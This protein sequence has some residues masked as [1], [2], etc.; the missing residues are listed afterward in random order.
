MSAITVI[1]QTFYAICRHWGG[2]NASFKTAGSI[3]SMSSGIDSA[4]LNMVWSEKPLEPADADALEQI[5]RDFQGRGLPFWFWVFPSAKT[6]TTIDALKTAGFTFVHDTPCML[7]D[8]QSLPEQDSD[9]SM[10]TLRRVE[11][12]NDLEL[13][14]DVSFSGFEFPAET[15]RQYEHFTKSFDLHPD[16][17][18]QLLLA[19][20]NDRPV[21]TSILFLT[22]KAAGIYFVTT[23]AEYRKKGIGLALTQATLQRAKE[24][25]VRHAT[26]QSSPDGL[27]VYE[28]AGFKEYCRAD[29]FS[30]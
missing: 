22:G 3:R 7:A 28:K 17:P 27:H 4:D 14:R 11:N 30:L 21:A 26:L 9:A 8:L 6:A 18:H 10:I 25:G 2:L 23:L 16:C 29:I 12:K 5:K 1:E 19:F 20:A 15:R 24:A 13:W